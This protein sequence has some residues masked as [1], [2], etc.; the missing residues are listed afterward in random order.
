[1]IL[2][3]PG[4]CGLSCSLNGV[5]PQQRCSTAILWTEGGTALHEMMNLNRHPAPF[6]P[7]C[8]SGLKLCP[9]PFCH[10][11]RLTH[12]SLILNTKL[13]HQLEMTVLNALNSLVFMAMAPNSKKIDGLLTYRIS[14][15][16]QRIPHTVHSFKLTL[17]TLHFVPQTLIRQFCFP[18]KS[19]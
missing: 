2:L 8:L 13:Y 1:M 5:F 4:L 14:K 12:S 7:S 15:E 19:F 10:F 3:A 16:N 17:M 18:V 9:S 11:S 6:L